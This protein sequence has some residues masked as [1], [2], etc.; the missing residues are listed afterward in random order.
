[1]ISESSIFTYITTLNTVFLVSN[2]CNWTIAFI[3]VVGSALKLSNVIC[4]WPSFC[5]PSLAS[6]GRAGI[7]YSRKIIFLSLLELLK[8][9][10]NF[11]TLH[12]K[13]N[14]FI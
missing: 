11:K 6:S 2:T 1:M 9:Q 4:N 13:P 8:S 3:I 12:L 10:Q 7:T 5:S 14:L